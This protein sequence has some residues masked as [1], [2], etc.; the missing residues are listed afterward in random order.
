M[1]LFIQEETVK[2]QWQIRRQTSPKMDGQQRWDRAYQLLLHWSQADP[3]LTNPVSNP[4]Q[5]V[6]YDHQGGCLRQSLD[7]E[8]GSN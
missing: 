4:T 1:I 7:C 3:L 6:L 5:E 2:R 8:P